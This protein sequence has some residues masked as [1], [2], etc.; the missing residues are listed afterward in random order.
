MIRLG[1]V[2]EHIYQKLTQETNQS[3]EK[4]NSDPNKPHQ[5]MR[6]ASALLSNTL[7][8]K[9]NEADFMAS[10]MRQ[11]SGSVIF[12]N[13]EDSPPQRRRSVHKVGT[14]SSD[15]ELDRSPGERPS[16]RGSMFK[17]PRLLN[18]SKISYRDAIQG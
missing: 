11:R 14:A 18:K 3:M 12:K 6:K 4:T 9:F 8:G 10:S 16:R 5:I 1:M 17:E 15:D 2:Y 13:A 7:Q